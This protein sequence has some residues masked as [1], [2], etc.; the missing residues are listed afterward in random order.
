MQYFQKYSFKVILCHRRRCQSK[1]HCGF[2]LMTNNNCQS[3]LRLQSAQNAGAR[4]I[5]RIGRY[6]ALSDHTSSIA[7]RCPRKASSKTPFWDIDHLMAPRCLSS[8]FTR[9]ADVPRGVNPYL[10]LAT[11]APKTILGRN[12]IKSLTNFSIQKIHIIIAV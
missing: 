1:A 2:L 5:V 4:F 9:V 12:F 11:N 7:C 8:N 10:S 6:D 3:D